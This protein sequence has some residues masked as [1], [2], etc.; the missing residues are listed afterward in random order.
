MTVN[1]REMEKDD[2]VRE[3]FDRYHPLA[4]ATAKRMYPSL[5]FEAIAS[6]AMLRGVRHLTKLNLDQAEK[7]FTK[8]TRHAGLDEARHEG[9]HN[10]RSLDS[11]PRHL[12]PSDPTYQPEIV[13]LNS[14]LGTIIS[15]SF[16][17]LPQSQRQ[18]AIL[19]LYEGATEQE[20]ADI[21][22]NPLG[23][24]KSSFSRAKDTLEQNLSKIRMPEHILPGL[25]ATRASVNRG[26]L[27]TFIL[28]E[29]TRVLMFSVAMRLTGNH[30]NADDVVQESQF[31]AWEKMDQYRGGSMRAWVIGIVSN[32]VRDMRRREQRR[33]TSEFPEYFEPV[34]SDASIDPL[35]KILGKETMEAVH[36]A[37]NN[38]PDDQQICVE[39]Y[40]IQ[41]MSYEQIAQIENIAV[42]TVKS[43]LSRARGKIRSFLSKYYPELVDQFEKFTAEDDKIAS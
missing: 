37:L 22:G 5:D 31:A 34:D 15:Q 13:T 6:E 36:K 27:E 41:G 23:T 42:G 38:L 24:V 19:R 4:L 17:S 39:L 8:A 3:M 18:I 10:A 7:W 11:L 26:E 29:V 35:K 33:P 14:E 21:T 9:R 40:D 25:G 28:D 43:R 30:A 12:E 2:R 32:R 20:T 16:N 1:T